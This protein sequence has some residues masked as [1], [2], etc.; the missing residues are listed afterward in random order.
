ML[1]TL[2]GLAWHLATRAL[3]AY[4]ADWA[5]ARRAEGWRLAHGTP[6]RG[7]WPLAARLTLPAPQAQPPGGPAWSAEALALAL[8][9]WRPGELALQP[10]GAQ[11][12]AWHGQVLPISA[13]WMEALSPLRPALPPGELVLAATGLRLATLAAGQVRLAL[14]GTPDGVAL[15]LLA[16]AVRLPAR[17]L[18][19]QVAGA[20]GPEWQRLAADALWRGPW[21]PPADATAARL[22]QQAGGTL[23]LNAATLRWGPLA[24]ELEGDWGLDAA[25]QPAGRGLLKLAGA[26][27]ALDAA[28]ASGALPPN[29]ATAARLGLALVQRTPPDG[30]PPR[31][32]VPI[33]IEQRQL[34]IA[35]FAFGRLAPWTW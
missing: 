6:V 24:A 31:I 19:E 32:E 13:E 4:V 27:A 10:A 21:P 11:Q 12:L 15:T 17:A 34:S 30:G 1:A 35:R 2:H 16:E 3:A 22:W 7:G 23:R 8:R 26:G 9:P 5:E 29:Q 18:P 28:S 25:L 33:A 14:R 20:L